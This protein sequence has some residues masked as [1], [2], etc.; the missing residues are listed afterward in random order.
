MILPNIWKNK[1]NVPNHPTS[2]IPH[3]ISI[4]I[5]SWSFAPQPGLMETK[6]APGLRRREK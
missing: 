4:A 3:D 5:A 6:G 2:I 1:S